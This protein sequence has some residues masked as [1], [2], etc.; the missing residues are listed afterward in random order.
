MYEKA[1]DLCF[2]ERKAQTDSVYIVSPF[3]SITCC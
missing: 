3:N 2:R 1:L